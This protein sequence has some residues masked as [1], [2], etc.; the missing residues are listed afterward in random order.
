[1]ITG[2]STGIG[3]E[4]ALSLGLM[5]AKLV[6]IGRS[7]QKHELVLSNLAENEIACELIEAELSDLSSVA[8]AGNQV[9]ATHPEASILVNNAGM[10][11]RRGTTT[12]GFE[13]AFGVN[14]LSHYL[15][16]R[17]LLPSLVENSPSRVVN[18]S[19]NGHYRITSFEPASGRGRTRSFTG[20][21]EYAY[22]KAANVAFT[23][24]LASRLA[25]TGVRSFAVHPGV[26]ATEGWRSIP[27]PIRWLVMRNMMSPAQG[28]L[29]VVQAVT[30]PALKSGSYL[31]PDGER[32]VHDLLL[33]SDKTRQLWEQSEAWV[34]QY[35]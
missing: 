11:G 34:A 27:Q 2:A 20:L 16:T 3:R 25:E 31:T 26:V 13:L 19:S 33:D 14:Y 9:R 18:V 4:A 29:A 8:A 21:A 30:D 1:V 24:E 28:S 6:L 15:L 17:L 5:G 7:R 10:G 35:L 32:P 12:D 22:S 23:L